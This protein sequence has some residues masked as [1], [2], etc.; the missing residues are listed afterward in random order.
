MKTYYYYAGADEHIIVAEEH[1]KI[2]VL[3][4]SD[5][6]GDLE[7]LHKKM[8]EIPNVPGKGP[9]GTILYALEWMDN[10]ASAMLDI[11]AS[12]EHGWKE[13][14]RDLEELMPDD[15]LIAAGRYWT[16]GVFE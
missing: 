6:T 2:L 8:F 13:T 5:F 4:Q 16:G 14:D 7:I 10:V 11:A 1:E 9:Y 12:T 3:N 15:R